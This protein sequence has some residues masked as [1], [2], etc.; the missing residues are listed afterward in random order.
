MKKEYV[1]EPYFRGSGANVKPPD[2]EWRNDSQPSK[3]T[4][5]D[6]L[7]DAQRKE[8]PLFG[9]VLGYFRD[10]ILRLAKVSYDGNQQHNPGQHLHWA[11]GKSTDQ[12]DCVLRHLSSVDVNDM[13]DEVEKHLAS[14][15]WRV[16]AMLQLYLEKKYNI[17]PPVNA[18]SDT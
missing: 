4:L 13:S 11:R 6:G 3:D 17:R 9:G 10:A 14:A 2:I 15:F 12:L 1:N 7:T 5:L 8:Y 18:R 16:G